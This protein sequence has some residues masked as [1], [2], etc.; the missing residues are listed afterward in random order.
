MIIQEAVTYSN[1]GVGKN[2]AF[3][4]SMKHELRFCYPF[5][6]FYSTRYY[7]TTKAVYKLYWFFLFE[8]KKCQCNELKGKQK[9]T[10]TS[11]RQ[12]TSKPIFLKD[13]KPLRLLKDLAKS[14]PSK[15]VPHYCFLSRLLLFLPLLFTCFFNKLDYTLT[16]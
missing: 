2:S 6:E 16:L 4:T 5:F 3:I 13:K 1:R 14:S 7:S 15:L 12:E 9:E 11:R 8:R 10:R